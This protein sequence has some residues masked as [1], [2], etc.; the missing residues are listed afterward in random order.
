MAKE[1]KDQVRVIYK[2][3]EELSRT[4]FLSHEA[5]KAAFDDISKRYP[6]P[7]YRV[8]CRLRQRTS[9]YDVVVKVRTEVKTQQPAKA[10]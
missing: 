8:R 1:Q 4:G 7:E 2:K 10:A 9:L 6:E 3:S 5:A